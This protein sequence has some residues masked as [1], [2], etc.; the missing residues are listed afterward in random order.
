MT[1]SGLSADPSGM[2]QAEGAAASGTPQQEADPTG[3]ATLGTTS[4][5]S[6]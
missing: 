4:R 5:R 1:Q 6:R 2:T 3:T